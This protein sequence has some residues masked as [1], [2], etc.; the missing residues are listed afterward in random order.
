[1]PGRLAC[2][3]GQVSNVEEVRKAR[4]SGLTSQF[5]TGE[6]ID[7]RGFEAPARAALSRGSAG[8]ATLKQGLLTDH[9]VGGRHCV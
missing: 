4:I 7:R 3:L 5:F 8:L 6:V 2:T 9:Y 1:M